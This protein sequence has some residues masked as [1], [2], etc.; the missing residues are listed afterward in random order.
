MEIGNPETESL[1]CSLKEFENLE[2][3]NCEFGNL[4]IKNWNSEFENNV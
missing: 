3:E 2:V 4:N 1:S